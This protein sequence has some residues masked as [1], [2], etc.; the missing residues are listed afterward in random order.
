MSE[1]MGLGFRDFGFRVWALGMLCMVWFGGRREPKPAQTTWTGTVEEL[2]CERQLLSKLR[3]H[4]TVVSI[5]IRMKVPYP[6]GPKAS[7]NWTLGFRIVG[8]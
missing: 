6:K 3:Q 2:S 1:P 8:I 4:H 7:N 5:E